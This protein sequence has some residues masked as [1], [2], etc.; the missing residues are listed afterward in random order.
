MSNSGDDY[1]RALD[2]INAVANQKGLVSLNFSY[3]GLLSRDPV[4]SQQMRAL[5]PEISR[6]TEL[7]ILDLSKHQLSKLPPAIGELRSLRRLDL[8]G[9]QLIELP[10]ELGNLKSLEFL[11]L[12]GNRLTSL[13]AALAY[14][15]SLER[16]AR[17][18]G[19][20]HP[21]GLFIEGES[22]AASLP[23]SHRER[24]AISY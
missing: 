14:L 8:S 22:F 20:T 12:R 3:D 19:G 18:Q 4:R 11:D 23:K 7:E 1:E 10:P 15:I 21:R 6:L 2:A 13:P 16:A 24:P 5:P 17:P 9:N